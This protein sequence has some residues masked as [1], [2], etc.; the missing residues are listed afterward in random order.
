MFGQRVREL[1]LNRKISQGALALQ[2]NLHRNF[3]G[4]VERG[5]RNI[6]LK[7]IVALAKALGVKPAKLFAKF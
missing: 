1:R 2:A 4:Q 7:N 3:V 6:S 5:E